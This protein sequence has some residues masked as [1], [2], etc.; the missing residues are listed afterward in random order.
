V[1]AKPVAKE[2]EGPQLNSKQ[3]KQNERKQRYEEDKLFKK[4]FVS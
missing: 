4:R 2:N 3:R 1:A